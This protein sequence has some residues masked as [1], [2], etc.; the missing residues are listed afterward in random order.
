M[1]RITLFN[2]AIGSLNAGD[3]IINESGRQALDDLTVGDTFV[4]EYPTHTPVIHAYQ[5]FT[6]NTHIKYTDSSDYKFLLGTNLLAYNNLRPWPNWNVNI[7][8]HRPYKGVVLAGVGSAPNAPKINAY[9][10][11]LYRKVLSHDYVHSTRDEKTKELLEGIGLRAVN[12][13]CVTLWGLT[14]DKC[15]QIPVAK[16]K[17]VVFTLTDYAQEKE[18]DQKLID[19]LT[20]NYDEVYFWPQGSDDFEYIH[21]FDT[22]GI[23]IVAPQLE[24]YRE[25]LKKGDIDFVGTRLHAGIFAMQN[26]VRALILIVDNRARDMQQSYNINAIER[27]DIDQLESKINSEFATD[28][29]IDTNK[30]NEWK[31]QFKRKQIDG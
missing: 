15:Q 3:Y 31:S 17:K 27:D 1:K 19:I 28:V 12:T 8:N 11:Y 13:G 10:K 7:F 26:N 5:S 6:K 30:I 18:K 2:T 24:V 29:R 9:T 22:E 16:S 23:K 25:L 20:N 21:E 4:V 14:K